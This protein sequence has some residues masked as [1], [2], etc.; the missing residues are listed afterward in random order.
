MWLAPQVTVLDELPA[1]VSELLTPPAAV[2]GDWEQL[3]RR[4]R[5]GLPTIIGQCST[6]A[7]LCRELSHYL[8]LTANWA[9]FHPGPDQWR[10]G[11]S[12]RPEITVLADWMKAAA[13]RLKE[14]ALALRSPWP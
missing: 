7:D 11:M 14:R 3:G 10:S 1:E 9:P 5:Q 6:E 12:L 2:A 8:W 4:V 13:G